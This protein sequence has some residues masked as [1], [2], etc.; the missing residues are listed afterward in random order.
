MYA[1]VEGVV[2]D[3]RQYIIIFWIRSGIIQGRGLSGSLCAFAPSPMLADPGRNVER[4]FLGICRARADDLGAVLYEMAS[5]RI[6]VLVL[7]MM[8]KLAGLKV[9]ISKCTLVPVVANMTDTLRTMTTTQLASI[10][11]AW[12]DFIIEGWLLYLGMILGPDATAELKWEGPLQKA[13]SRSRML[14]RGVAS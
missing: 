7:G 14:G 2:N 3:G 12:A 4:R 5:L 6:M 1:A 9:M 10:A 11:G 8:E 13:R